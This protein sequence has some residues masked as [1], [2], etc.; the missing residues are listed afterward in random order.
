MPPTFKIFPLQPEL[1]STVENWLRLQPKLEQLRTIPTRSEMA[2]G[3]NEKTFLQQLNLPTT[4]S[5]TISTRTTKCTSS[6]ASPPPSGK[7]VPKYSP[8]LLGPGR[9]A[10]QEAS[11]RAALDALTST[12]RANELLSLIHDNAGRLDYLLVAN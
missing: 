2:T 12:Y 8:S 10:V 6:I 3:A 11:V 5:F 9:P 4:P 1:V 7:T